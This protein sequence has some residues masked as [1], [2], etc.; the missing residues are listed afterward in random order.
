MSARI[1]AQLVTQRRFL[2]LLLAQC[3]GS[4]NDNLF[5]YAL[6]T[7][8]TFSGLTLFGIERDILVPIAASM[9]TLPIFLFSAIAGRMADRFDRT[10]IMRVTKQ[11]EIWIMLL[12]A[13]AL[14][15]RQPLLLLPTLFL[16]GTQ[17]AFFT[18]AKNAA[19]PSLMAPHELVP[20]N[21]LLSGFLNVSILA[22]VALGTW[23][24]VRPL[25]PEIIGGALVVIAILGWLSARQLP[26][27]DGANPDLPLNFN[28]LAETVRVLGYALKAPEVLRPLLGAAWF[29]ML[30][31]SIITLMPVFT[32][33][34]LGAD[35]TVVLLFS[36]LFTAGAAIGAL[37]CGALSGKGDALA[38]SI[39]GAIGLVIFTTDVALATWSN[40]LVPEG[41]PLMDAT[42]FFAERGNWRLLADL[43]L[44]AVSAGLFVVPLQAM[45][46]RRAAPE[47]RG[48]LLA[49]GGIMNAATAT[50]GQFTLAFIA[51]GQLPIQTA[52][53]LIAGGSALVAL[54]TIWRLSLRRKAASAPQ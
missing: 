11:I 23:L 25:G 6:V 31:A 46:Q 5:R 34:V 26:H 3:L 38:F 30:A 37:L 32:A 51:M 4:L 35:E 2:P 27:V 12:A 10:R 40:P 48:R 28:F 42:A 16:M 9:I 18:P 17:S 45:A 53:L 1:A 33:S 7:M 8:V 29:W 50:L 24:A 54:V 19:L 43:G 13:L 21:A 14:V 39:A 20:A 15:L 41:A 52:F 47:L 44:A 36:A 49:A 22:G